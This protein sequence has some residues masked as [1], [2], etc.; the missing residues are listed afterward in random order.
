MNR[1][2]DGALGPIQEQIILSQEKSLSLAVIMSSIPATTQRDS[3]GLLLASP[4][5]KRTR[6]DEAGGGVEPLAL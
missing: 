6:P 1:T 2:S 5:V 4:N 3:R